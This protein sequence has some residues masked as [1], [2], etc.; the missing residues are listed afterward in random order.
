MA[1]EI[2]IPTHYTLHKIRENSFK[3]QAKLLLE[4]EKT[5]KLYADLLHEMRRQNLILEELKEARRLVTV[6]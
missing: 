1:R 4:A 6:V 5:N 2:L 3:T